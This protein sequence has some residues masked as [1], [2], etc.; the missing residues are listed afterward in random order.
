RIF[1]GVRLAWKHSERA[2]GAEGAVDEESDVI[3]LDCAGVPGFDNDGRLAADGSRVIEITGGGGIGGT[4]APDDNVIEAEG[5]D[6]FLGGAVLGFAASGAPVCVGAKALVE[7][8]AMVV[9]EIVA[10]VDDFL[11]EEVGGALGWRAVGFGGLNW[12]HA[13]FVAG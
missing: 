6:H 9:N 12:S 1:D 3:G 5:E 10:A 7:V 4:F 2:H 8:A 13:L 11:S